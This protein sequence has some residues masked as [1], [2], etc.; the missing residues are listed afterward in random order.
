MGH[1]AL[2]AALTSLI[3]KG[4][5]FVKELLVAASFGLSG[6]L[7][8][9][10]MAVVLIGFPL[11]IF[12]NAVQTALISELAAEKSSSAAGGHLCVATTLITVACI[13]ALL[14]IWLLLLPH[15]LPWLASGF[16][17]DKQQELVTALFWLIPYYFLNGINLLSYGALQARRRYLIN[18]LLPSITP[19]ATIIIL[20]TQPRT[21]NWRILAMALVIGSFFECFVL[22]R[23]L[24][25]NNQFAL[26]R[27]MH[28]PGLK[29]VID[30][31]IALLPGTLMLAVGP[32]IEQAIAA[33]MGGGTIASLGYGFKLPSAL[34]GVLITAIGITALPY[35]ANQL[36]QKRSAY[37]LYSLDKLTLCLFTA[38]MLLT[39]PLA[40]FSVEIVTL[41]Y[42]RGAFDAGATS[43]VAPI[44]FAYFM[45]LPF[46]LVAMLGGKAMAALGRNRIMSLYIISA[47]LLQ[48]ALAYALG[49]HCG[50]TGIA[51]AATIISAL[52]AAV[53]Y[54]TARSTLNR[55]IP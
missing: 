40:F 28:T 7:D 15:I 39:I 4:L 29:P 30:N 35:F 24:Y 12:L 45:Q 14:P 16:S 10:L 44:Q 48:S 11:S 27:L 55:L 37:C 50:A 34:Q 46:A 3:G 8:I 52:L 22:L 43:R 2:V 49:M 53:Y 9:Y 18:G 25:R 17:P 21:D 23:I 32:V 42:Q 19:I 20:N 5:G 47:V 31:T 51:W 33:S 26:P 1:N 36:G 13:G 41:I 54:F 38:G 6:S